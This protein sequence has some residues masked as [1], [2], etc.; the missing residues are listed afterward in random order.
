MCVFHLAMIIHAVVEETDIVVNPGVTLL[1]TG[2]RPIVNNDR[3]EGG[4]SGKSETCITSCL[5][6][7]HYGRHE[8]RPNVP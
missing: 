8:L 4:Q 5:A 6:R 1:G 2:S 7:Y 3:Q